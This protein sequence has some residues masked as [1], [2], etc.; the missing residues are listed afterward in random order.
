MALTLTP[1]EDQMIATLRATDPTM[2]H[3]ARADEQARV[4]AILHGIL[5]VSARAKLAS[6]RPAGTSGSATMPTCGKPW[7]IS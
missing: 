5:S 1:A 3:D 7:P 4:R 6:I 2:F